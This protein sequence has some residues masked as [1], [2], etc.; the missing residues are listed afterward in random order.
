MIVVYK[1][2]DDRHRDVKLTGRGGVCFT[3]TA[4]QRNVGYALGFCVFVGV[5]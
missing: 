1:N 2:K 5:G 3:D 4:S